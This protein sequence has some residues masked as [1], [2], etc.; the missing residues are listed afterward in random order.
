MNDTVFCSPYLAAD[1][2]E[3]LFRRVEEC[4]KTALLGN[5]PYTDCQLVTNTI[6]LLLTTGL[7]TKL[8]KDWDSLSRPAQMWIALRTMIQEAFRCHLNAA[9]P[10]AGHNRY[11]PAPAFCQN[12]FGASA[13]EE[14]D[15]KSVNESITTQVAALMYQSQVTANM[16]AN[17]TVHQEQQMV[18]LASQQQLM[19]ENMHQ[20]IRVVKD[21]AM[22]DLVPADTV[23]DT[24]EE[25]ARACGRGGRS[26]C[27]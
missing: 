1:A 27:R 25:H 5:N 9:T 15:D 21:K 11:A 10:T 23:A 2:P 4:A 19:Y 17:T 6:H 3:V 7:N 18:H 12:A 14:T 8:F 26:Y 16:A 24:E 20:S 22:A 13:A